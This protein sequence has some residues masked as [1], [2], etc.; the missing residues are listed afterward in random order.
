MK[1]IISIFMTIIL[2]SCLFPTS[3]VSAA[4]NIVFTVSDKSGV[5]GDTVTVNVNVSSNSK[6]Q[7]CSMELVYDKNILEIV[8]AQ[9]GSV[10]SGN[11]II[12]TSKLGKVIFSYAATYPITSSGTVLSATFRIKENA[13]YGESKLALKITELAD[14]SF[15]TLNSTVREGKVNVI[16][17]ELDSPSGVDVMNISDT[18]A[19]VLWNNDDEATGYNLYI[20]DVKYNSSLITENTF[21]LTDL[22]PNTSY[23]VSVTTMHYST[24]SK[25]SEQFSFTTEEEIYKV[26]FVDW[27][28]TGGDLGESVIK[29]DFVKKGCDAVAPNAPK[30]SGYKFTGW[31]TDYINIQG[32]CVIQATYEKIGILGDV[33][34]DGDVNIY[35][36]TDL[37]KYLAQL[38]ILSDF[39]LELADVNSDGIV[40]IK[41]ATRIQM[42][43]AGIVTSLE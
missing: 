42:Y 1:K 40:D 39:Q 11:P 5:R 15:N 29:V 22:T 41:E 27:R 6:V 21:V 18:S 31:D 25:K 26:I 24:E 9:K 16:A 14:G 20:N 10:L 36:V 17:P 38:Q 35:D 7:A 2:F 8:S 19:T 3:T 30:R 34:N 23:K 4:E 32:N 33:N 12:N 43:I 13:G 28:Y 37:Q